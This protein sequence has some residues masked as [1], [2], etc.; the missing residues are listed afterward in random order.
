VVRPFRR[1]IPPLA[2]M[3]F[4]CWFASIALILVQMLVLAPLADF[5]G[6]I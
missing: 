4:S 1:L 5:A 3:D 6:R 2:G